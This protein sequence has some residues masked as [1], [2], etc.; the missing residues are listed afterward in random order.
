MGRRKKEPPSVHRSQIAQAASA[1]FL[2]KGTAAASMDDIAK[3]AGY[4]KATLYVYFE[5]KDEIVSALTLDS[6]KK[7]AD[8]VRAALQ[9]AETTRQ[10]Y[11]LICRQL[12]QYQRDYPFYF[13]TSL[14]TIDIEFDRQDAFPEEKET[15]QVGEQI[16]DMIRELLRAGIA[17][18]ELRRDID[19]ASTSF[20]CWGM[21][22]G[23][24]GFAANKE[25][26]IQR[27]L[28]LSRDQFLQHGFD[29]FYRS[30]ENPAAKEGAAE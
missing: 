18:G 14:Q 30:L 8:C 6:M 16:N 5:N 15:Y 13:Q 4:S 3:A 28:G 19:L 22:A 11:D 23:F 20:S 24:I 25:Q 7:L 9:E 21:L 10:K 26:Y 12:V 17:R 29:L 2:E 27:A 1:L